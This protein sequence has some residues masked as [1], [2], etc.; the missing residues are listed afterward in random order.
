MHQDHEYHVIVNE[1]DESGRGEEDHVALAQ[2]AVGAARGWEQRV[3]G[4]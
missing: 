4:E 2:L 1:V 3:R